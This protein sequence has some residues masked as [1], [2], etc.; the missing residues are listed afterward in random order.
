MTFSPVVKR[1]W[2]AGSSPSFSFVLPIE[3]FERSAERTP[4]VEPPS[5]D[6]PG[7]S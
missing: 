3:S 6:A 2:T 1:W 4:P 5:I 7:P